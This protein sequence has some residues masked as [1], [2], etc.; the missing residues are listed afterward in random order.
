MKKQNPW[1]TETAIETGEHRRME[2]YYHEGSIILSVMLIRR[3]EAGFSTLL[4]AR[5]SAYMRLVKTNHRPRLVAALGR[6]LLERRAKLDT[7]FEDLRTGAAELADVAAK[8]KAIFQPVIQTAGNAPTTVT[9][10]INA[11]VRV[12]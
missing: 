7:L 12:G 9:T 8:V 3:H 6:T 4:G 11:G 1:K 2:I 10:A 5:G